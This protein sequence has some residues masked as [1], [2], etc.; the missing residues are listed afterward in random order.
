MSWPLAPGARQPDTP[1][2]ANGRIVRGDEAATSLFDRGTRDGGGIFE[3][4]R[5][6]DG[7][8]FAWQ[9]HMERLVL[10]A[11]ELGFP[12]PP[13]PSAM[14]DAIGELLDAQSLRDAVV[15]ITVTRGIAGGRPTRAG[16]WIDAQP[17][18]ARLWRGTR[19]GDAAAIVSPLVFD[20]GWMGAYKTT[21]R[22]AW[23][24][25]REQA[26]AIGADEALLVSSSGELLEGS[27]S[28]VFVVKGGEVL[29]PPLSSRILPGVT[30]AV[31]LQLCAELGIPA[32]ECVLQ[33]GGLRECESL[34]LTNSV[35]EILPVATLD[36]RALPSRDVP[37]RLL[38]AYREHVAA[39]RD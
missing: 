20:L 37:Q 13:R 35:Q 38:A 26:I 17:L 39:Q 6:Y 12:V 7:R 3:T 10:A 32:R 1:I 31:V 22:M 11:A 23:D 19:S 9:R 29:T 14:R 30:R 24:L 4:L 27:A 36:G 18:G 28:N 5:V 16:A 2:W 15:R 33:A 8:P 25:A 34:F 21:S